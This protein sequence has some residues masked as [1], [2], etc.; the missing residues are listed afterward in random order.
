MDLMDGM[1]RLMDS[2]GIRFSVSRT[3][4]GTNIINKTAVLV[5]ADNEWSNGRIKIVK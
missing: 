2:F 3:L 1:T 4:T 5:Q